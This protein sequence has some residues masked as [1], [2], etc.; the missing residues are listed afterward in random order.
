MLAVRI[1]PSQRIKKH[2]EVKPYFQEQE[3]QQRA[4]SE[5]IEKS[6]NLNAAGRTERQLQERNGSGQ[7]GKVQGAI[8]HHIQRRAFAIESGLY[9]RLST[10]VSARDTGSK[11]NI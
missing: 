5:S 3:S 6:C 2:V 11:H 10:E 9:C 4:S 1:Y 8:M 7:S